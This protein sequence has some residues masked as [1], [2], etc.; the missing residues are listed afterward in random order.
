[1]DTQAEELE[2]LVQRIVEAVHPLK[3]I[4][5]G[6]AAR[7]EMGP[8][9]DVDVLVVMPEDVDRLGTAEYLHTQFFGIPLAV[10]V[11]VA[12][13]GDLVRY[14]RSVGLIYRTV[15]EEGREL[16]AA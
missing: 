14:G 15:L 5:F 11:V 10:D 13:P 9:S 8:D 6:S 3:I 7:G 12:T 4:L 2:K 1:M 16:Y